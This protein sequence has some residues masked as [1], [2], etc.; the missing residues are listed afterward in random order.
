[1]ALPLVC[2]NMLKRQVQVT[3]HVHCTQAAEASHKLNMHLASERVKHGSPNYTQEA[4]L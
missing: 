4:M 3:T 2:Q 1:M